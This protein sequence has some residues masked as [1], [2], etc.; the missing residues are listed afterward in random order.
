MSSESSKK[1]FNY[2][3]TRQRANEFLRFHGLIM[4]LSHRVGDI[5]LE[6]LIRDVFKNGDPTWLGVVKEDLP[7]LFSGDIKKS[8]ID[9]LDTVKSMIENS[10]QV[11]VEISF[12]PSDQFITD[13]INILEIN[14]DNSLNK[15]FVVEFDV[16]EDM[17]MGARFYM[18]GKFLD[19]TIRSQVENYL[20]SNDVVNRYI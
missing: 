3:Q 12:E 15:G 17:D 9:V 18:N 5:N 4:T 8:D 7:D 1:I 19:L 16:I 6:K 11:K 10:D 13:F 14:L 20:I 2:L